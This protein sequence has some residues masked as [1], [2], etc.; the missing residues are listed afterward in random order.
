M[1]VRISPTKLVDI[2][3]EEGIEYLAKVKKE[4]EAAL[5][6]KN[7]KVKKE[8]IAAKTKAVADAQKALA[9]AKDLK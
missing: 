8:A 9:A 6:V 3:S 7:A 5:K 4:T 2:K 1:F